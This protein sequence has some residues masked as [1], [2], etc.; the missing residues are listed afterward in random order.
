[1]LTVDKINRLEGMNNTL[2]DTLIKVRQLLIDGYDTDMVYTAIDKAIDIIDK[3]D[4]QL[5]KYYK[6]FTE[7]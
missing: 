3:V 5:S 7:V 6:Q 1:M 4:K 2:S